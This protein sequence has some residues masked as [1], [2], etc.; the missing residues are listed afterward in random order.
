MYDTN[1]RKEKRLGQNVEGQFKY[2]KD[3]GFT[4]LTTRKL[5]KRMDIT[6]ENY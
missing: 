3:I 4:L 2:D 1:D 5:T 6:S